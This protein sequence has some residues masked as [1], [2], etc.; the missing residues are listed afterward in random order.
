M[1]SRIKARLV[2]AV[3]LLTCMSLIAG[4]GTTPVLASRMHA[5]GGTLT[6]AWDQAPDTLNPAVTG[7]RSVGP[8]DEQ[9]FDTL[10]WETPSGQ[11]TPD[12]ATSWTI[13]NHGRTFTFSLRHGVTFH[14]GTPFNPAAVVANFNYIE[15]PATHSVSSIGL[16]GSF[17]SATAL[18][19]DKVVIQLKTPYLP[20]LDR[21]AEPYLGMQ[22]PTAIAKYG[23]DVG[24]HPTGTG[25]FE[26]VS[27]TPNQ[28]IVLKRNPNYQWA[29]PALHRNGPASLD[30]I[31][32]EIITDPQSRIAALQNGEV[33]LIDQTP[34][35]FY[36]SLKGNAAYSEFADLI[37]GMG[38]FLPINASKWP[39]NDVAV[40]RA[41]LY[42]IDR[43]G[44]TKLAENGV[45]APSWGPLQQGMIG[46]DPHLDGAYSYDPRKA[47]QILT[48]DGW[49][50]VGGIWTKGGKKLTVL[51]IAISSASS[52]SRLLQAVQ[53]YL[54]Q[55][56]MV[57]NLQ[58]MAVSAWLATALKGGE[59]IA[60][61]HMG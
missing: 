10:V 20:L 21:L 61:S 35:V 38:I 8:I 2:S 7:A 13:T 53:G 52:Q 9:I 29:P 1:Q 23:Q 4:L 47:A 5:G 32:F 14:D 30:G 17:Q 40:R 37:S 11:I 3:A 33:Q 43:V 18:A 51:L 36:N 56:G 15:N 27:Y 41:M 49:T 28:K 25:P 34:G 46:Y 24:V 42:S 55:N 54:Q 16:I 48:A 31:T 45:Y 12:L 59:T 44:V 22:S 60:P 19:N 39:T 50:K 58:S 26:F 57:A 6:I